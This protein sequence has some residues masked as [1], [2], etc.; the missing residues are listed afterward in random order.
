M[1]FDFNYMLSLMPILLKY[2]PT[3]LLMATIGAIFAL[4]VGLILALIRIYQ[5]P[6]LNTLTQLYISF[7]RGTPLLVQLFL[8]YYGLP[9]IIPSL[10]GLDAFSAAV[11]GLSLHFAAYMA[12]SIRAAIT[13]VDRSQREASLAIGMTEWQTMRRIILPQA[14]RIAL[15]SLMNYFIDMIKS[16]SLA[17]T[18]GVPE[19]MAKA[20]MEASSSF[21]FFEA[22]LAVAMI[23]WAVVVV[24]TRLQQLAETRLDRAYVR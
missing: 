16:T 20:Q 21:K 11:I 1:G 5:L 6:L 3:T 9:Q 7:F 18:L 22:F 19:I 12:E 13:G 14:T 23:Y 24:L 10:V 17:F 2:L 8:L 4:V 15:P